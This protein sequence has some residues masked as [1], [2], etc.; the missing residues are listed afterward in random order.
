MK[1]FLFAITSVVAMCFCNIANICATEIQGLFREYWGAYMHLRQ[2]IEASSQSDQ[3]EAA[4]KFVNE[5]FHK[6]LSSC[7]ISELK[8]VSRLPTQNESEAVL[9]L[10][11]LI[12]SKGIRID[13]VRVMDALS[14]VSYFTDESIK[15]ATF[16]VL[17]RA[18]EENCRDSCCVDFI[19]K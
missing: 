14:I 19:R 10:V 8:D 5:L 17:Y 7:V 15:I 1:K 13:E 11:S 12:Q 2:Q 3:K 9:E 4:I 6:D 18:K 16:D